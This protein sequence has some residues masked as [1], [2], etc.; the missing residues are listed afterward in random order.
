M[1]IEHCTCGQT[2]DYRC[3]SCNQPVCI[4]CYYGSE[5]VQAQIAK[6][7]AEDREERRQERKREATTQV[8][9]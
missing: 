2:A 3:H 8:E 7:R 4:T 9:D 5:E 6:W 1:P